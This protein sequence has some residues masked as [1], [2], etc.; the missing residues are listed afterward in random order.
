MTTE[1]ELGRA[2]GARQDPGKWGVVWP[3]GDP[4]PCPAVAPHA[5]LSLHA[6]SLAQ[7]HSSGWTR[8]SVSHT[9]PPPDLWGKLDPQGS[10]SLGLWGREDR[11]V[12]K[13]VHTDLGLLP[14]R[15]RE[16]EEVM[17]EGGWPAG[18]RPLAG[19]A[20]GGDWGAEGQGGW[21]SGGRHRGW[22]PGGS[23]CPEQG[24]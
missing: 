9:L 5:L 17:R 23:R 10:P 14:G 20:T 12:G 7:L 8:P 11:S 3:F 15:H 16:Q 22:G 18:P 6:L 2:D 1:E 21:E 13:S 19:R 24:D 4:I